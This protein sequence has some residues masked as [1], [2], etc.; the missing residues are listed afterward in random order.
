MHAILPSGI[1]MLAALL[2]LLLEVRLGTDCRR[3]DAQL[4]FGEQ[5]LQAIS[6]EVR[7]STATQPRSG[8]VL[9]GHRGHEPHLCEVLQFRVQLRACG[10]K[11]L[12]VHAGGFG[13]PRVPRLT[14]LI[15]SMLLGFM[16]HNPACE[17]W[18]TRTQAKSTY[19][20]R[21]GPKRPQG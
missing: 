5:Q 1:W 15:R 8:R 14:S 7:S 21:S 2:F 17:D 16:Q 12:A 13:I 11:P 3:E 18:N 20:W 6:P 19:F 9:G 4:R 10:Q